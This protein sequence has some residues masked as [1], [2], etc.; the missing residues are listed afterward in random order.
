[1]IAHT[2]RCT[3]ILVVAVVMLLG[4][5][6]PCLAG[7]T[8]IFG[9]ASDIPPLS[10]NENGVAK[11]FFLDVFRETARR[12]GFEITLVLFPVKRL[13][14]YLQSGDIDGVAALSPTKE[15]ERYL[16]YSQTPIMISRG[17]VFVKK[18]REFPFSA[19]SDLTGKRIGIVAGWSV[20]DDELA[21]AFRQ[22]TL[23]TESVTRY[24]QNLKKLMAERVDCIIGTEQLTWYHAH[25]LGVAG[26]LVA[27]K[28][29]VSAY[30]AF[31]AVGRFA[32]NVGA[33]EAF[34]KKMDA[35]LRKI[36]SD[37]TYA[38][39]ERQYKVT[40]LQ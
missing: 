5:P 2:I 19:I 34:I 22:G 36:L 7:N 12:A 15:R 10:Y 37:G 24:D 8:L 30:C 14:A 32:K 17:R 4:T 16:I 21:R 31:Y 11:G 20:N 29:P 33:P 6:F 26:N 40:S 39:F 25:K 1:M 27:L 38:K 3:G 9:S 18:G 28:M 13:E 23:R 35:A